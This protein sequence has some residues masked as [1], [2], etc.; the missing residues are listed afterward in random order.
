MLDQLDTGVDQHALELRAPT[1]ELVVF[2]V[3]AT[4]H[5]TLVEPSRGH[6]FAGFVLVHEA[7]IRALGTANKGSTGRIIGVSTNGGNCLWPPGA[8]LCPK[9]YA[10]VIMAVQ[11]VRNVAQ[12]ISVDTGTCI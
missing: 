2:V 8:L 9:K 6:V 4:A 5:D 1:Q 3:G 10:P 12:R 7:H 11:V